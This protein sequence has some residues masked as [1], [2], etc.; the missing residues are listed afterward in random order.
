MPKTEH[1]IVLPD[2][3]NY[4][5]ELR[6]KIRKAIERRQSSFEIEMNGRLQRFNIWRLFDDFSLLQPK[7]DEAPTVPV[8]GGKK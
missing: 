6:A 5:P 7:E 2:Y 3:Q 1:M 4:T 8:A